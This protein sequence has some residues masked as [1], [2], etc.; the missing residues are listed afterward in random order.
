L[1][2]KASTG[3]NGHHTAPKYSADLYINVARSVFLDVERRVTENTPTRPAHFWR[4][5]AEATER[6]RFRVRMIERG[7]VTGHDPKGRPA[8]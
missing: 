3:P 7:Q 2:F 1:A 5:V 6:A 4:I 8:S